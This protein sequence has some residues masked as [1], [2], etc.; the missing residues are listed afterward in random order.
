MNQLIFDNN[1]EY[2]CHYSSPSCCQFECCCC[3]CICYLHGPPNI[4]SNCTF[5][6]C[7]PILFPKHKIKYKKNIKKC[8]TFSNKETKNTNSIYTDDDIIDDY[9]P[10]SKYLNKDEDFK[11][12]TED[13]NTIESK[14]ENK[15]KINKTFTNNIENDLGENYIIKKLKV[16]TNKKGKLASQSVQINQSKQKQNQKMKKININSCTSLILEKNTKP[17]YI[18]NYDLN[19]NSNKNSHKSF[20]NKKPFDDLRKYNNRNRRLNLTENLDDDD[21]LN[22][23]YLIGS[24]FKMSD[25]NDDILENKQNYDM[26]ENNENKIALQ[27]LNKE[28]DKANFIIDNLQFENKSIKV[29][30][31]E[32]EQLKF[33]K[34]ENEELNTLK[35]E[36]EKLKKLIYDKE[37]NLL[38]KVNKSTN[39][40][41]Y[42]GKEMEKEKKEQ[43]LI[44]KALF[45]KEVTKLKN[46]ISEIT[47]KLNECE[48]FISILKQK[49]KEQDMIIKNKDKEI[50][51]LTKELRLLENEN[52]SKLKEINIKND[53]MLKE[54]LN[55][56][57]DLKTNNANLKLEVEKLKEILAN[58]NMQIKELE[59]K[60]KYDNKLESKKQK[61][62]EILFNFYLNLK[63]VINFDK[64]KES[65]R[66]L[67][68][69]V[70]LDDFQIKLNK[71]EK[72][73]VQIID[74]VQIKYGHCLA[75]DIACCTSHVD[76]LKTFR[77]INPKKK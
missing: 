75:C 34:K 16:N 29:I 44:Q 66:N 50:R 1:Q 37:Q 60:L 52:K 38:I 31:K 2:Q 72:K 8:P 35:K 7:L 9:I 71:V 32:N 46:E 69:V 4:N 10:I 22:S 33:L 36:N 17:K 63:K 73:F 18:N 14:N 61:L 49:N 76:K 42:N 51:D 45:E 30:K 64:S 59:I 12:E 3:P 43:N 6:N 41:Y 19:N 26:E 55:I 23:N 28:I 56:S 53:E 48:K 70:P 21:C 54:S 24:K 58:K 65:L 77:K 57:T 20:I 68:E 5:N 15:N 39:T 67:I 11:Y 62:L 47:D 40:P 27:N 13:K 74:D 25:L